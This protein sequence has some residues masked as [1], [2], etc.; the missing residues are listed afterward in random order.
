[1]LAREVD[2]ARITPQQFKFVYEDIA[3]EKL[4]PAD[5][6]VAQSLFDGSRTQNGT[7]QIRAGEISTKQL[8]AAL[9]K[10]EQEWTRPPEISP[11]DL[12]ESPAS[13]QQQVVQQ[14]VSPA[15]LQERPQPEQQHQQ[16]QQRVQP[17]KP[18][19]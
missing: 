7:Q 17:Q 6:A 12:K 19:I 14:G 2:F 18:S 5:P 10:G 9:G 8:D 4:E 3:F 15:D 16:S 1:V 11:A 13:H